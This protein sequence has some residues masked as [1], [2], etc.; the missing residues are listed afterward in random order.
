MTIIRPA[1]PPY[2]E[3]GFFFQLCLPRAAATRLRGHTILPA[4][5]PTA[6]WVGEAGGREAAEEPSK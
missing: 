1:A 6:R 4:L 5:P 3:G 2:P